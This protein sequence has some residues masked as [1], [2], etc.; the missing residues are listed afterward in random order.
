MTNE[1]TFTWSDGTPWTNTFWRPGEPN[2][3][4]GQDCVLLKDNKFVDFKCN[5]KIQFICKKK[6][7]DF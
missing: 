1:G 7:L 5:H 3:S 6:G 4:G 2:N